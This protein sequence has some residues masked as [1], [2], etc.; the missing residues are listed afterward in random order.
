MAD[1]Y[2]S[3]N[4]DGYMSAY[5][6]RIGYFFS[7]KNKVTKSYIIGHKLVDEYGWEMRPFDL[8]DGEKLRQYILYVNP[9]FAH[10]ACAGRPTD[11]HWRLYDLDGEPMSRGFMNRD[12]CEARAAKR[13]EKIEK[14]VETA[15]AQLRLQ[16]A[17]T[18][19]VLVN[20]IT[21]FERTQCLR[22]SN[23]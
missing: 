15:R 13:Q 6:E 5:D 4:L 14:E 16:S 18:K 12:V 17:I 23:P 2:R 9:Q 19:M 22:S 1:D 11:L 8:V 7:S 20:R 21:F 3:T 10:P